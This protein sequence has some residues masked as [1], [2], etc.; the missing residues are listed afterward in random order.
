MWTNGAHLAVEARRVVSI[1]LSPAPLGMRAETV[2]VEVDLRPGLPVF[3][4]VG[5]PDTAVQ[6]AR[7]RVRSGIANQ[8]Y[9]IPAQRIVVNLAPGSLRKAGSQYD[10]PVALGV[11]AASGQ[12]S[13][14]ALA[15][16]GAA[17]EIALDGR[18]RPVDGTLAMAEH[19]RRSGWSRL[20]VAASAAREAALVPGLVILAAESLR[21][22]VDL[23]EGR[24]APAA[25]RPAGPGTGRFADVPDLSDVHG[26][27]VA[28]RALEIAAAGDHSLLMT[29]PPG[30]G[31]TMLARRL[32]GLLPPLGPAEVLEV[33]RVHSAAGLHP[34]DAAPVAHRPFRDPHHSASVA[35]LVGGGPG[36]RPGEISLAHLGVLFLDEVTAFAP[37]ALDALRTPLQ[38][39]R[40]TVARAERVVR[41]PARTLLVAAGNPCPCGFAGDPERACHCP[42]S[43]LAAYRTRLSGPLLDRVALAVEVP[44]IDPGALLAPPRAEESTSTVRER[45]LSARERSVGRGGPAVLDGAARRRLEDGARRAALTARA[46]AQVGAVASTI[47]DLAGRARVGEEDVDE[48]LSYQRT[49]PYG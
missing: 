8:A 49:G 31:K 45:V 35:A 38:D 43:R 1:V 46:C 37:S 42:E 10:L 39:G 4:V 19:A 28:R 15:G 14:A 41:Y 32:A 24:V 20:V 12:M 30:G 16:A 36:L 25:V 48:A 23:L 5:L 9:A 44:R 13:A 17:A 29:G 47:A 18:L 3:S 7:E 26:Q 27:A 6:E 11:L 33:T 21:H 2:R 40:V 22:A 34:P